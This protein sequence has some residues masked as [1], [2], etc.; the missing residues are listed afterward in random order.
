MLAGALKLSYFRAPGGLCAISDVLRRL[1][2]QLST[3]IALLESAS[4]YS[5]VVIPCK[6]K[7]SSVLDR[8]LIAVAVVKVLEWG[9][10][11]TMA[12][13]D[14]GPGLDVGIAFPRN[15][16]ALGYHASILCAICFTR[17]TKLNWM[18][19]ARPAPGAPPDSAARTIS[20]SFGV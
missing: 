2:V 8:G 20:M 1:K 6:D 12:V 10:T 3:S 4:F 16:N 9:I 13:V 14:N 15:V 18:V 7:P 17:A 5:N 11:A 19:G